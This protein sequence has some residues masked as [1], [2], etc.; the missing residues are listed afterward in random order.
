MA[1]GSWLAVGSEGE[2]ETQAQDGKPGCP[3]PRSWP[4]SKVS[5]LLSFLGYNAEPPSLKFKTLSWPSLPQFNP[6]ENPRIL[7]AGDSSS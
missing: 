2:R 1:V 5:S 3:H 6:A 7:G 4:R